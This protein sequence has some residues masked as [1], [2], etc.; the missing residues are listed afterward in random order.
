MTFDRAAYMKE[1]LKEYNKR[2]EVKEKRAEYVKRP[3]VKE[4]RKVRES[5]PE[6]KAKR[7]EYYKAYWE[8]KEREARNERVNE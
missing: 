2:P 6:S 4:R 8:R 7:I 3:E 5:N 1:Y